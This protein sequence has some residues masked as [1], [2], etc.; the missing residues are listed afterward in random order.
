M[1]YSRYLLMG[2]FVILLL[3]TVLFSG[4]ISSSNG[5]EYPFMDVLDETASKLVIMFVS[6]SLIIMAFYMASKYRG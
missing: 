2:I 1:K 6:F 5:I 3:T 4:V